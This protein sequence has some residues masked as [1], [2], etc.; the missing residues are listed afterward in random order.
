M[1]ERSLNQSPFDY[2]NKKWRHNDMM[3]TLIK[4]WTTC[5][6]KIGSKHV[7]LV[8]EFIQSHPQYGFSY[9]IWSQPIA[10]PHV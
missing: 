3:D 9:E 7:H 1:R 5:I 10:I 2:S 6:N 8:L 4:A